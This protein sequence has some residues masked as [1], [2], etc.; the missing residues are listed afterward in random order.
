MGRKRAFLF[1]ASNVAMPICQRILTSR[2]VLCFSCLR[3]E[4]P[5]STRWKPWPAKVDG[6]RKSMSIA[7][8]V[9]RTFR[10]LLLAIVLP[11]GPSFAMPDE[12]TNVSRVVLDSR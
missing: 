8:W 12:V 4:H 7:V 6:Q 11:W 10:F 2:N 9:E 1:K 5:E 3:T